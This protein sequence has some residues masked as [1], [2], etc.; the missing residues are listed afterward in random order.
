MNIMKHPLLSLMGLLML[1]S[2]GKKAQEWQVQSPDK[3]LTAIV[4]LSPDS[5]NLSYQLVSTIAGPTPSTVVESSALGLQF[6][7]IAF[8]SGLK[9]VSA[10]PVQLIADNYTLVAG[11]Q[12]E[13][14][15][16]YS[17]L[18]LTF[19]NSQGDKMSIDLRAYND[20]LA[21]RYVVAAPADSASAAVLTLAAEHTAF[22]LP[23][24]G[25]MWAHAYDTVS[26]WAPGYETFY[27]GPLAIG[28][29]APA[30]KNGWA[31]PILFETKGHWVLI[32][33]SNLGTGN[34]AMHLQPA[35]E[36]G[37]FAL[38]LPEAEEAMGMC[39]AEP[40]L[41]LPFTSAW[42]C[43]VVAGEPGGIV[44]SHMITNCA[45]A[46]KLTDIS[47]IKPGR[48]SWSWWSDNP[49]TKD[50]T[51]LKEFVDFAARMGWE[52]SLV[53][54]NWN[55][56]KGGDLKKLAD[57]A[58]TK[59]VNLLVWYN[60]GGANNVVTEMP[61]EIMNNREMRRAEFKKLQEWGIKGVKIDFFQSDK[62]C[63]ITQYIET[64]E[65]AAEYHILVNFHGCTLPRGWSR[66]YPHLLTMEAVKGAESYLFD[67]DYPVRGPAHQTMLPFTRNVVGPM[68]YTPVSISDR[69]Y[70]R[71]TS[72]AYELAQPVIFESGITHF[73]DSYKA[74]EEQPGFVIDYL[75][76]I[77][78]V[79]DET[80]Y[81]GGYPGDFA[82][83]AR[84]SGAIWYI[85]GINGREQADSVKLACPFLPAGKNY[86][87]QLI[88]DGATRN[89]VVADTLNTS[90]IDG[91]TL[92]VSAYG[93]FVALVKAAE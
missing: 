8:V 62:P 12:K 65:D 54:A 4:S 74:Y 30:N 47:W 48:A 26:Q 89:A 41:A 87:C 71:L 28:T 67:K 2:C 51:K 69:T 61:R 88:I 84:R 86:T 1:L 16:E 53:D 36:G 13:I 55:I 37:N 68:D 34:A 7:E 20:G 91:L 60:S 23:D 92:P 81:V 39:A 9:F 63:M 32:S 76:N 70:P 80:R 79:W 27:E 82:V 14:K 59:N 43:I 29:S 52:Y 10:E 58:K 66:T 85:A 24:S 18:T 3:L 46:S 11:R 93:G 77:P 78:V 49:S 57:Y 40:A 75:K 38:R 31:F 17:L 50:Y 5:G 15:S 90:G 19:A 6:K 44:A 72:L 83:I 56:M 33:E 35:C 73:S 42:R 22:N 21:F 45:D 64:L 25:N